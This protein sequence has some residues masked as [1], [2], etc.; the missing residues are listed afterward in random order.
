MAA[1]NTLSVTL[2]KPQI[3]CGCQE[4]NW[5]SQSTLSQQFLYFQHRN[6]GLL[7]IKGYYKINQVYLQNK[8]KIHWWL[9]WYEGL[10]GWKAQNGTTALGNSGV[11]DKVQSSNLLTIKLLI[12]SN[13]FFLDA[14]GIYQCGPASRHAIK[15][16]EVEL[17][18]DCPFVFAEVN[19]D[20]MYWNYDTATGKKT[21]IFS[22]P[23]VIGQ[24]ISTKAV[25]R[26]D[27]VDVTNDYK[28]E[29]GK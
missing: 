14:V 18:Y 12:R 26:D 27:R 24:F 4:T 16:G 10:C 6:P 7:K 25:G 21:L 28:Y 2:E 8:H 13:L 23:T 5:S 29:E 15:E 20:C 1:E 17:D 3:S 11:I 19:A 9:G 22:Q